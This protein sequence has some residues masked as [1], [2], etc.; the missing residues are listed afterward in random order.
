MHTNI[1]HVQRG[2]RI[3]NTVQVVPMFDFFIGL[4]YDVNFSEDR[5]HFGI[6]VGYEQ[7]IFLNL[8]PSINGYL[9]SSPFGFPFSSDFSLQGVSI[10]ARFD[11]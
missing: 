4:R 5:Y 8:N 6:N 11:F 2:F 7:H 10:G 1:D 9:N 3:N